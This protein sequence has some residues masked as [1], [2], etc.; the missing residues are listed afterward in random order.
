MLDDGKQLEPIQPASQEDE[1][2]VEITKRSRNKLKEIGDYLESVVLDNTLEDEMYD[3][4]AKQIISK[5]VS[6]ATRVMA[7]RCWKDLFLDKTVANKKHEPST[8][9]EGVN[10]KKALEEVAS[11]M[12]VAGKKNNIKSIKAEAMIEEEFDE[13]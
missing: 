12:R 6:H 5:K 9:K 4:R 1:V 7:A 3:P 10:L 8:K 13:S 2:R 11:M